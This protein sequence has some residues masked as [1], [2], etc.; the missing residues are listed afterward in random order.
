M[1]GCVSVMVTSMCLTALLGAT[2]LT[3]GA[4]YTAGHSHKEYLKEYIAKV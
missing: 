3:F 2:V 4:L 1:I